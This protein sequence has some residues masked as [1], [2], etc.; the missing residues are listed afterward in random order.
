MNKTGT[1][2]RRAQ[3]RGGKSQPCAHTWLKHV[4]ICGPL[5][6]SVFYGRKKTLHLLNPL[7]CNLH[8]NA[9]L[10]DALSLH[11]IQLINGL[12]LA[13]DHTS[14][15]LTS[16]QLTTGLPH[17]NMPQSLPSNLHL[18]TLLPGVQ[19]ETYLANIISE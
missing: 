6:W 19:N 5:P 3:S 13:T 10:T 17:S 18:K 4:F 14:T 8:S 7:F 16:Q 12:S 1:W 15:A 9:F 2:T 11:A